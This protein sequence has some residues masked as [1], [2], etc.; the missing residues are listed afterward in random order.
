[1]YRPAIV[2][3]AMLLLPGFAT[4]QVER[5]GSGNAQML[6]QLQQLASER[7][8]L[9]AD[10]ARLK[11]EVA[12]MKKEAEAA[13]SALTAIERRARSTE[14]AAARVGAERD[15]SARELEQNR[16]RTE[17]LIGKFRETAGTLREVEGE[18]AKLAT[19]L[20][21]RETEFAKCVAGNQQLYDINTEILA[22][23]GDR[24]VWSALSG[25]EPFTQLKRVQLD[26][27]IEN[28]RGRA[29]DQRLPPA[30]N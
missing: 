9:Q 11:Q 7:T 5:S 20:A 28:Y 17:E 4:A 15:S 22:R 24:G 3:F 19:T 23:L 30:S 10:N 18:R 21:S 13:K 25:S 29:D 6:Q 16:A 1:M 26:N 2:L 8:Q 14:T 12:S 27:L